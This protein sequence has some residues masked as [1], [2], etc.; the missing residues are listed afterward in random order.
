M[1]RRLG[2]VTLGIVAI[3]LL[4]LFA[5]RAGRLL[6]MLVSWTDGWGLWGPPLFIGLYAVATI[7]LVPASFLTVASGALFGLVWGTV[8][9]FVGATLGATGAFLTSRYLVRERVERRMQGNRRFRRI[10]RAIQRQGRK[11]VFLLRLSPIF[12]FGLLNYALGLTRVRTVDYVLASVGMLPGTL[13]YVYP[14]VLVGE[15]AA[16]SGQGVRP[17]GPAYYA[18]LAL[19]LLATVAVV[20]LVTRIARRALAE[21]TRDGGAKRRPGRSP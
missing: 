20:V 10:D 17:R 16:L 1:R 19:G 4:M 7:A 18:V 11:V 8:Y 15:V 3:A 2:W 14:G 13:L 12:P 9:A 5:S 6:P 21:E